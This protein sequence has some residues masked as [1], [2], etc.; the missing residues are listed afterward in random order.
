MTAAIHR[1]ASAGNGDR[2]TDRHADRYDG[3]WAAPAS[4][5]QAT[6]LM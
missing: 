2:S 1:V 5:Y 6:A 4:S 3:Y